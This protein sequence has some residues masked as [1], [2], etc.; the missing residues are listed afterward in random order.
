M[1]IITNFYYYFGIGVMFNPFIITNIF[2]KSQIGEDY[3]R[4]IVYTYFIKQA[5]YVTQYIINTFQFYF[6][7]KITHHS[8]LV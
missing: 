1:I 4:I 2:H 7:N 5:C 6:T 8:S 3:V